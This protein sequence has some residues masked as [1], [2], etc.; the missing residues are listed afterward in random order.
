[1][2]NSFINSLG[3]FKKIPE[4]QKSLLSTSNNDLLCFK[5]PNPSSIKGCRLHHFFDVY[6][7]SRAPIRQLCTI[8]NQK[9]QIFPENSIFSPLQATFGFSFVL[10]L[11]PCCLFHMFERRQNNVATRQSQ[12]V[13][14]CLG[15]LSLT[16]E[17]YQCPLSYRK[18]QISKTACFRTHFL[19]P[20]SVGRIY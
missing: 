3:T 15:V 11:M 2:Q 4:A 20:L 5:A 9:F 18:V 17:R 1:M 14:T 19:G 16:W 13:D 12:R 6:F 10:K 7:S 8:N